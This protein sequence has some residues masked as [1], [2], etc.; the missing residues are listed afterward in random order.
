MNKVIVLAGPSGAGKSTLADMFKE[1]YSDRIIQYINVDIFI[2]KLYK[3]DLFIKNLIEYLLGNVFVDN[4]IDKDKLFDCYLRYPSKL[5][6]I[7]QYIDSKLCTSILKYLYNDDYE[8]TDCNIILVECSNWFDFELCSTTIHNQSIIWITAH[9]AI[10]YDRLI[11]RVGLD[12][13]KK[14]FQIQEKHLTIPEFAEC[15]MVLNTDTVNI[16]YTYEVLVNHINEL[17][18]IKD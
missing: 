13:A 3:K 1:E 6:L 18:K 7:R 8:E 14:I 11:K 4:E 5:E 2:S 16:D 9:E 17:S 15:S 10:R 12:K